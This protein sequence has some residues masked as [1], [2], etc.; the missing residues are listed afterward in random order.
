MAESAQAE[1]FAQTE[2]PVLE[3]H[4]DESVCGLF[5]LSVH[6]QT[7][8]TELPDADVQHRERDDKVLLLQT[9][10]TRC[11]PFAAQNI[12]GRMS[13]VEMTTDVTEKHQLHLI[14]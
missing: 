10:G 4:P 9:S 6:G 12:Q 11:D 5:S 13:L 3:M 1:A 8:P 2:L 14:I 7:P